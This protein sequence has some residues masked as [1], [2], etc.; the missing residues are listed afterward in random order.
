M[1]Q[2]DEI[3]TDEAGNKKSVVMP[4]ALYEQLITALA[5]HYESLDKVMEAASAIVQAQ[6]C[7]VESKAPARATEMKSSSDVESKAPA[8]VAETKPSPD[9]LDELDLAPPKPKDPK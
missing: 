2:K 7:R 1:S 4:Y 6:E 5:A 3:I 8:R 9:L